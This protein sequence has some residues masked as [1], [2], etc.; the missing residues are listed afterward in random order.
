M[1]EADVKV[2]GEIDPEK[3]FQLSIP[4]GRTN[5]HVKGMDNA[6]WGMKDRLSRIFQPKSGR[7]LMLAFDHG[8]ITGA[9]TGLER[10]DIL[11]PSLA[12]DIDVFMATRG[13]LRTCVPPMFNKA[14][15]LRCTAGSTVLSGDVTDETI[16]V[17]IEDA[18]RMN[19]SCMAVQ[20][21]MGTADEKTSLTNLVRT[22]DAGNRYGIP[23]LG[24]VAVGK[25]MARSPHFFSLTT[26]VIAELGAQIVKC[27]YCEDFEK[28]A[29]G[30]PVPIVVAGGKKLPE[31][32]ALTMAYRAISEGACGMDMGRNI[33]QAPDPKAMARAVAKIVHEEYT[34]KEAYEYY[35]D[36]KK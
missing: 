8:Y 9:S 19:A 6:D 26:R 30:C 33:F 10:L 29:A 3:D 35:L 25:Q 11:I 24:V 36:T 32:Q 31:D 27:Y 28:V 16:G 1:A 21:F 12:E 2:R 5:F 4:A 15:A 23:T 18:I 20:T 22:V 14:V 17:D 34:D 7:T 13:A